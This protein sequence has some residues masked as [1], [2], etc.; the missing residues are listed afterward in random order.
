MFPFFLLFSLLKKAL[1]YMS[2]K[3]KSNVDPWV[4]KT[5]FKDINI[6]N[7]FYCAILFSLKQVMLFNLTR[8]PLTTIMPNFV[9]IGSVDLFKDVKR[10]KRTA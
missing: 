1:H 3:P 4:N 2:N 7:L 6:F 5:S 10:S 8:L 9:V